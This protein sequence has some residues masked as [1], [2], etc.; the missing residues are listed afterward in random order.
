LGS[1]EPGKLA[2][3]VMLTDDPLADIRNTR[4]IALVIRDGVVVHSA[5][6]EKRQR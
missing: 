2:D 4:R 1:I 3:L 6:P 5:E